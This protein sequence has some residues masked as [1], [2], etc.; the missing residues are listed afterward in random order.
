MAFMMYY[1]TGWSYHLLSLSQFPIMALGTI[2]M[3]K[4][5]CIAKIITSMEICSKNRGR[6]IGKI[7]HISCP[8]SASNPEEGKFLIGTLSSLRSPGKLALL[9]Y[10]MVS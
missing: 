7:D 10:S 2:S 6:Q 8:K 5:H 9:K 3:S 4:L 1:D